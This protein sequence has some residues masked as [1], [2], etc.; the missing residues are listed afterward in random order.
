VPVT[1]QAAESEIIYP[2]KQMS[3]LECRFEE[4][5]TLDSD[6]KQDFLVLN[7]GDYQKYATA[8]G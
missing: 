2:L 1:T 7:T 5:G 6:C 4:F 3:K 8:G